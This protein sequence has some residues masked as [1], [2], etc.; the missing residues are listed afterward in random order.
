MTLIVNQNDYLQPY[1]YQLMGLKRPSILATSCLLASAN[2]NGC[3]CY[4]LPLISTDGLEGLN[5]D[6]GFRPIQAENSSLNVRII[7]FYD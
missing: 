2:G 1:P 3:C 4:P 5:K 7:L 6:R